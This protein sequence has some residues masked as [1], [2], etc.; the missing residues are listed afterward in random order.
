[1]G[2]PGACFHC[3]EPVTT[4]HR[5]IVDFDTGAL[6]VCCPGCKAVAEFIRDS[7][8][9]D[10]YDF[11][12]ADALRPE[13]PEPDGIR[14][15]W[16]AYDRET[17]Q[18]HLTSALA[19]G[20]REVL[21]LVEG[22]RCA[23]CSW[24]IERALSSLEGLSSI[25]INPATARGR[26]VWDPSSLPLSR[27]MDAIARLGY[28]PHPV[29]AT[30]GASVATRE[31]RD[32]MKR[33]VVAGL[34]MMQVMT[35][36]VSLYLGAFQGMDEDIREFLRLVSLLVATPVVLYSG[37]PF[38][39]GAWRDLS[40]GRPGMD[41]PVA[42]AVGGAY[43]AS[44]YNGFR[45]TGEVYFDSVTMFVFLLSLG[46]FAEMTARHR[47][48]EIAD[49]LARLAPATAL[50]IEP[51]HNDP[52][53]VG[54]AELAVGD[55]LLVRPGDPFPA[56][57]RI[58]R[59]RTHV[60]ESMLTGESRPVSRETGSTVTGGSMNSGDPVEI[61]V[62]RIGADTVLSHISRLLE[63]AQSSRPAL[64]RTAD[65]VAR[66]FVVGVLAIA[67][68]VAAIW[69]A[70]DG[71]AAFEVTLS[72]LVVTC[73]CALSLATPTALTAAT[74]C[75]AR[76]G[77]LVARND[78][79]EQ[80]S[81]ADWMVFDKTGTLTRAHVSLQAVRPLGSL[82][83]DQCRR[84]AAALEAGSEHPLATALRRAD[85]PAARDLR[86]KRGEGIEGIVEGR[87]YRVGSPAFVAKLSGSRVEEDA[88]DPASVML[89]DASGLLAAFTFTDPVRL[90][91]E[92][93]L[94]R[95]RHEGLDLEI[96]SGDN[97]ASVTEVGRRLGVS[98]LRWR[99]SPEDKLERIRQLQ[100]DGHRVAMVG[101]GVNDAPVLAG[102]D[103]SVAMGAGAPLAQTSADMVLLGDSLAP[104]PIG[105][106]TAR[107]A[108][109]II[110]QNITWA[111]LYNLTALPLAAAGLVAPW[112]AAIGMS[113]SSLLVVLNSS[114]LAGG[115]PAPAKT[116]VS[117]INAD[118]AAMTAHRSGS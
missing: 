102:A 114:R 38:F 92:S 30:A 115:P 73:P 50:R 28:R 110:R 37:F 103:V 91:V 74:S 26:V 108:M 18:E 56:D 17:L 82:E 35:Y 96:L 44:L 76:S 68:I 61:L 75:L 83:E 67:A 117:G 6:P 98:H 41:V 25:E 63:R 112:M 85:A 21:L 80:L 95:L 43:A 66:W 8:L 40:V 7:G 86:A 69:S 22:V 5:Y 24:L 54:V 99:R 34:G 16:L 90:N 52:V 89:G 70:V 32:A 104:L 11:R 84:V 113:A 39:A 4:G 10:Y 81:K 94:E 78:A 71:S 9:S 87:T 116:R 107:K 47:A 1:M 72:V 57:G 15:E 118:Q 111:I 2:D 13:A 60:D 31:R 105:V 100:A 27:I 64:A 33:L 101:D 3:G 14:A 109:R 46:R 29:T 42:L 49:S 79:L 20:K 19:D 65:L 53:P 51:A 36:A 12:T 48:G 93:T 23:A 106:S 77:L 55:R 97:E 88:T 58:V 45:G 62:E 59:G